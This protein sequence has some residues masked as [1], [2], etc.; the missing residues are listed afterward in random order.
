M[1]QVA[2]IGL[3]SFG[4]TLAIKL[5][6]NGCTV[7]AVDK[8]PQ[9]IDDIKSSVAKA[10]IADS[11]DRKIVKELHLSTM[12][13]VIISLGSNLESS[14]LTA[15]HLIEGGIKHIIAKATSDD[16]ARILEL[17][18]VKNIV[19]PERD[20]GVRLADSLSQPNILD[21]IPIGENVSIIEIIP[22]KEMLGKSLV[23]LDFR[24]KYHCQVIAIKTKEK[25]IVTEIPKA[26]TIISEDQTLIVIG[27]NSE[28]EQLRD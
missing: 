5:A 15:M 10:V 3:S 20:M 6:Q 24:N 28:L 26:N 23:S 21:V 16:H 13:Y 4:T 17:I 22:K 25:N 18:G 14:V 8:N 19:F 2:V 1:I 27:N 11:T 12:D 7:L 9:P